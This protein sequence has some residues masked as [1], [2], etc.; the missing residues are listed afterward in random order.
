MVSF[1]IVGGLRRW[2]TGAITGAGL[3]ENN[4]KMSGALLAPFMA[5]WF[6]IKFF[7]PDA[8]YDIYVTYAMGAWL[9]WIVMLWA[10]SKSDANN[11]IV[12]PQSKWRFPDGQA[13]TFDLKVPPDSWI[14]LGTLP[15]GSVA[16]KVFFSDKYLYDDPDLPFPRVFGGAYWL[17]PAEWDDTF[18]RRSAGEFFHKGIYV[19]KPDCEDISVYVL[20]EWEIVDAEPFP[21]CL[22]NDC[23]WMYERVL[24]KGTLL[25]VADRALVRAKEI[26]H[27]AQRRMSMKLVQHIGYLEDRLKV[28]EKDSSEDFKEASDERLS[29]VRGRHASIMSTKQKLWTRLF[30][31]KT[32]AIVVLALACVWAFGHFWLGLW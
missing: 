11:Y 16:F 14:R 28:A 30:N 8:M 19:T 18:R 6:F 12:F 20:P 17:L 5:M 32:L 24:E 13:R 7:T 27:R 31:L 22:I 25:N 23:G 10:Y 4:V 21:V 2:R 15:D 29:S 1:D 9:V 3:A 26:E